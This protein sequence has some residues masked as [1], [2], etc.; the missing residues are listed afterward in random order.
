MQD[1][2]Y[3]ARLYAMLH[4]LVI[5]VIDAEYYHGVQ[6]LHAILHAIKNPVV[7]LGHSCDICLVMRLKSLL[8]HCCN[9]STQL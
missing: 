2:S 1:F 6:L 5:I 9:A 7:D 3:A 4:S 8:R